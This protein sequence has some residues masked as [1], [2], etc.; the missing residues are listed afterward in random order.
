MQLSFLMKINEREKLTRAYQQQHLLPVSLSQM[1]SS[2][3]KA[4][5]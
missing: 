3:T 2:E 1:F 4:A 5:L